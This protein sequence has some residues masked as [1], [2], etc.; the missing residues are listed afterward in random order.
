[1]KREK[2]FSDLEPEGKVTEGSLEQDLERQVV[3]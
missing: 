2:L 1:M 3:F